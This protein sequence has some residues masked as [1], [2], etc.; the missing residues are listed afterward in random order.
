MAPKIRQRWPAGSLGV[1]AL[2]LGA[3]VLVGDGLGAID[4][5][6]IDVVLVLDLPG[7][8]RIHGL[9]DGVRKDGF[10]GAIPA[11]DDGAVAEKGT[12]VADVGLGQRASEE[13]AAKAAAIDKEVRL[14]PSSSWSA[15]SPSGPRSVPLTLPS[16]KVTPSSLAVISR[17]STS[18]LFSMWKPNPMLM[19]GPPP[20]GLRPKAL[21]FAIKAAPR[22]FHWNSSCA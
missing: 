6:A 15:V 18:F 7:P 3:G 20:F 16:I 22:L 12:V 5:A 21:P 9:G 14:Q 17:V 11:A 1:F 19:S 2:K 10:G 8:A 4:I 13:F